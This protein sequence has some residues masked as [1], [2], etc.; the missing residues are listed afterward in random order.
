MVNLKH[1]QERFRYGVIAVY[2]I[3]AKGNQ[4]TYALVDNGADSTFISK[5]LAQR[6]GVTG[7]CATVLV[8]TVNSVK[9]ENSSKVSFVV[10]P[11]DGHSHVI[12]DQAFTTAKLNLGCSLSLIFGATYTLETSGWY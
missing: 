2:V 12:V 11:H 3:D 6:L 10:E 8:T 4:P 5:G 9:T 1:S 7:D